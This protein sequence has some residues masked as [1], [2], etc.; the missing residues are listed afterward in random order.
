MNSPTRV[1]INIAYIALRQTSAHAVKLQIQE[2]VLSIMS[3]T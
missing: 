2:P 3:V 1:N